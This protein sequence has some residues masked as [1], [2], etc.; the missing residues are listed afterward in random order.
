M[1]RAPK[2]YFSRLASIM[3]SRRLASLTVAGDAAFDRTPVEGPCTP[4]LASLQEVL[5][6]RL[7]AGQRRGLAVIALVSCLE[8]LDEER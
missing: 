5:V 2:L 4:P 3:L 6:A 8:L 7:V 1:N